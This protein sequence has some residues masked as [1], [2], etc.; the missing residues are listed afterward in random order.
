MWK[1]ILILFISLPVHALEL[2]RNNSVVTIDELPDWTLS[3]DLF[4][5]PFI[6]F[7][8]E[9]NGQRSNIS[10]TDTEVEFK[11]NPNDLQSTQET[12]QSNKRAWATQVNAKPISFI[13][14]ETF[15]NKKGHQVHKIG[16]NYEHEGK[17]YV[18]SSYYINCHKK[19][20]FS[21]SLRLK[22][23]SSHESL[24]SDFIHSLDCGGVK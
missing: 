24:F 5:I 23:N 17:R 13:P 3:K 4:G 2:K 14:F 20:I 6:Y 22:E 19:I 21:K 15:K 12:Y 16:F 7:S 10:F 8:P 9:Q 11:L 18:E 1:L